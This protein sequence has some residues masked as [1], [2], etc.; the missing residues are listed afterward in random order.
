MMDFFNC[1]TERWV[2]LLLTVIWACEPRDMAIEDHAVFFDINGLIEEQILL[3]DSL[4][5]LLHKIA[6][7][8]GETDTAIFRP[9][10]AGWARELDIFKELDLNRPVLRDK[11]SQLREP[12]SQ[13][14]K[15]VITYIPIEPV[16]SGVRHLQISFAEGNITR[17]VGEYQEKSMLYD[18]SRKLSIEFDP[19]RNG[20]RIT[21]YSIT[22]SQKIILQDTVFYQ[23]RSELVY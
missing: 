2:F 12:D 19:R 8:D 17:L 14:G 3:L 6:F 23:L 9:D 13:T 7:L 10:S 16:N 11:Y 20:S 22:G 1:R 5:P 21:T 15:E 18:A 4:N